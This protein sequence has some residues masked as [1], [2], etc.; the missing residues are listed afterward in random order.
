MTLP[1]LYRKLELE[2][3]QRSPDGAGGYTQT[4]VALGTLW[5]DMRPRTG[6]EKVG[7]LQ[8]VSGASW[9]IIVRASP[10][11]SASR[12]RPEQR[13]REGSRLFH[14]LAV[15]EF[16]PTSHYLTCYAREEVVT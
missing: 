1:K 11:G 6:N 2:E 12:P 5:A 4:W 14:I 3:A 16:D 9:R 7:D 10:A 13:F 15:T 8:S